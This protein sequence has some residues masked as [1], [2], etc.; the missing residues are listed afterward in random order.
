MSSR[1]EPETIPRPHFEGGQ[2]LTDQWLNRLV[3]WSAEAVERTTRLAGW[4]IR[5]GWR[6]HAVAEDERLLE[7]GPGTLVTPA[8]RVVTTT[9]PTRVRIADLLDDG[10]RPRA[11]CEWDATLWLEPVPPRP[12]RAA[13]MAFRATGR[14][15]HES[16]VATR[17]GF[18]LRL[19]PVDAASVSP[20]AP[21]AS[22]FPEEPA[23]HDEP[24]AVSARRFEWLDRYE[25]ARR[26]FAAAGRLPLGR[27]RLAVVQRDDGVRRHVICAVVAHADRPVYAGGL[28]THER[29]L[30]APLL[31]YSPAAARRRLEA[32]GVPVEPPRSEPD[33][34]PAHWQLLLRP[35]SIVRQR[36]DAAG[37]L[38]GIETVHE[39]LAERLE[40]LRG[41]L[42]GVDDRLDRHW[43]RIDD[44]RE[45]AWRYALLWGGLSASF[46]LVV[47]A[48][49]ATFDL[50]RGDAF[51]ALLALALAVFAVSV[52]AKRR[53][54]A[55]LIDR[56]RRR[57]RAEEDD[58]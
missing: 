39:N 53:L 56:A 10:S 9:A 37:N 35:G 24:A 51:T 5:D 36:V 55:L 30:T 16:T 29:I 1:L 15:D 49:L 19:R 7:L 12:E 43:R 23:K 52:L 48:V 4:G 14:L 6:L 28:D 21:L 25:A 2:I 3:D 20:L 22:E 41:R 58:G 45:W 57:E 17:A 44:L 46:V 13:A 33:A 38:V 8:G 31:E 50:D 18:V 27:L 34:A 32:E 47:I 40:R 54:F 26:E 42:D 11:P